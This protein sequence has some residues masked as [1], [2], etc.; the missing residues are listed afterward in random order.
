MKKKYRDLG[1]M[2]PEATK[3]SLICKWIVKAMELGNLTFNAYLG[4]GW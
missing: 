1:L 3:I 2:N 4:I